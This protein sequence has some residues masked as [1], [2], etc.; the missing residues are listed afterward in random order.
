MVLPLLCAQLCP[1]PGLS[2]ELSKYWK[3]GWIDGQMDVCT[4]VSKMVVSWAVGA[5]AKAVVSACLKEA[6]PRTG[7]KCQH[8]QL[9]CIQDLL[10]P[11][12]VPA[13]NPTPSL[14][15]WHTPV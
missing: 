13:L 8:P 2:Q 12:L 1:V 3:D 11:H 7:G 9:T 14:H 5:D 15:G 10:E 6:E 4:L